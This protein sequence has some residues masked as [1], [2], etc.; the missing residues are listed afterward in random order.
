MSTMAPT[1]IDATELELARR[2]LRHVLDHRAAGEAIAALVAEGWADLVGADPA[3]AITA[4]GE[5]AGAARSAAPVV[6]LAV[7]WGA[8]R[9]PDATVGVTLD[10]VAYAVAAGASRFV[11]LDGDRLLD[12]DAAA[13]TLTPIRGIDPHLALARADRA[14]AGDG[15]PATDGTRARAA[16][17]LAL[18]SQM[19]GAVDRMLADTVAYV[20]ERHQY[21]RPIGSFQTV[22]HRL[23]DVRVAAGAARAAVRA[24][25]EAFDT[26]DGVLLAA[27]AKALAGRAQQLASTH[28]F[29]VHGG[30]AFTAEHGFARWVQRGL[31]LDLLLG[32]HEELTREVGGALAGGHPT[33]RRPLL[34]EPA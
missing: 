27:A 12:L 5:E 31:V 22:K 6:T 13:V 18:A 16:G 15:G 17:R 14:T 19:V 32:G 20:L 29:Q 9:E 25:W 11:A 28:C 7:L 3:A 1:P 30:I 10:G 24:A 21:G 8:G 23:A 26:P 34:T 2:S 4:L 33:P